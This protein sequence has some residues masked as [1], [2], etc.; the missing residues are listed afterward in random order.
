MASKTTNAQTAAGSS[1][2]NEKLPRRHS[3]SYMEDSDPETGEIDDDDEAEEIQSAGLSKAKLRGMYRTLYTCLLC[4]FITGL[5]T[6][7]SL[8]CFLC[9]EHDTEYIS[10][11][12]AGKGL[13][14]TARITDDGRIIVSLDLKKALPDLPQDYANP[15]REFAIDPS[16]GKYLEGILEKQEVREGGRIPKMNIVI[17]IVGSRGA[18]VSTLR[19]AIT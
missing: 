11:A 14:S 13:A 16:L 18:C 15:V 6:D 8:A 1:V 10:F 9:D 19:L 12:T 3:R 5:L 2:P 4:T 7:D 17:M